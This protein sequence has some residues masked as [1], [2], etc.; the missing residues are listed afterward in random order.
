MYIYLQKLGYLKHQK[1]CFPSSNALLESVNTYMTAYA[2]QEAVQLRLA[3]RQRQEPDED[4]FVKVTRGGR[5]DPARPAIAQVQ[6]EKQKRKK[7]GADDFYRFQTR[8][9][10]KERAGELVKKFEEDK[11]RVRMMREERGRFKVCK[12]SWRVE[13]GC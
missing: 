11:E 2:A 12:L 6:A 10:K 3:A 13:A 8:E 5:V 7:K 9:K 4:G 1:L